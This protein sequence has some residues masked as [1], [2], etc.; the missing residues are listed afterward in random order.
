MQVD[1][2]DSVAKTVVKDEE[3]GQYLVTYSPRETGVFDVRVLW[4]GTDIS[5]SPFHPRVVEPKKV[6]LIGGWESLQD[7]EGRLQL[8][9]NEAKT[10]VFDISEAGPGKLRA[11]VRDSSNA[12]VDCCVDQSSSSR[13]RVAITASHHGQHLVYLYWSNFPLPGSPM[14]AFVEK[15]SI[16]VDNSR[17]VLRGHGLASAQVGNQAEFTIDGSQA[18]PGVPEVTLSGTKSD[19]SVTVQPVGNNVYR[20]FYQAETA[21]NYLL[22]VNWAGRQVS[23]CPLRVCVCAGGDASRVLCSGD[24][25]RGTGAVGRQLRCFIDTRQAGVGELSAQCLAP[26]QQRAGFC[27]LSDH[28]DGTFTLCVKP[29]QAGRHQLHVKY[30]GEHVPGS[31]F[32]ITVSG[33]PDP[34]RVRVYGPGVEPGVLSLFQSRFMCD[35]RGAGAGQL[36][37]R[38]RGPK[39]AFR[40]EMQRESQKDRIISCKYDPTEPGDYRIEVRWAGE[41]V[42][43]S[44]FP[45][46]IFDTQEE[47]SRYLHGGYT[48]AMTKMSPGSEFYGSIYGSYAGQMSWRGSQVHL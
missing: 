36:T 16:T 33:P 17:V 8:V 45:V 14:L 31:P 29:Q 35:T 26:H 38:I 47:L 48:P 2:P 25:V 34:G 42:P 15:A 23:G 12:A 19:I 13:C 37:V 11:D 4:N 22:N 3:G 24:C 40:V 10:L 39:G 30:T 46:A 7:N 20:A 18:G 28:Q 44:P 27:E 32:S 1:G 5:G 41:H 21:G 6:R 9:V 43:G